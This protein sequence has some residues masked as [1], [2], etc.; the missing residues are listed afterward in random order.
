MK[1]LNENCLTPDMALKALAIHKEGK[2]KRVHTFIGF[3]GILMGCDMDLDKVEELFKNAKED[4]IQIA[5]SNMCAVSHAVAV[6]TDKDGWMFIS[7]K[8][9]FTK[10]VQKLN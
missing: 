6:W 5:G 3:S 2:V 9:S 4:E 10:V 1:T 7:S 8:P